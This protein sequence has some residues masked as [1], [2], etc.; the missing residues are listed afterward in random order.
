MVGLSVFTPNLRERSSLHIFTLPARRRTS[1][2]KIQ[3]KVRNLS[4]QFTSVEKWNITG[5][6]KWL[7]IDCLHPLPADETGMC[8]LNGM[9]PLALSEITLWL[10]QHRYE[11]KKEEQLCRTVLS[12]LT[13]SA[14]TTLGWTQTPPV[15]RHPAEWRSGAANHKPWKIMQSKPQS[16]LFASPVPTCHNAVQISTHAFNP[17]RKPLLL[18]LVF[19]HFLSGHLLTFPPHIGLL[20]WLPA[21]IKENTEILHAQHCVIHTM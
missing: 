19:H 9:E 16:K 11:K 17:G 4:L 13:H 15:R 7:W 10:T 20:D 18:P 5:F 3:L 2:M 1:G 12:P 14:A 8:L 21:E 6:F